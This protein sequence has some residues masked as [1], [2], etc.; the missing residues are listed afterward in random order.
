[1]SFVEYLKCVH[2]NK[3]TEGGLVGLLAGVGLLN[4]TDSESLNSF[5]L[6]FTFGSFYSLTGTLFGI[7]T[8]FEYKKAQKKIVMGISDHSRD[9]RNRNKYV[10]CI[11]VGMDLAA[12]ETGLSKFPMDNLR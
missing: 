7:E 6:L 4:L 2:A 11:R 1:M 3:F 10:Y 5:F 9:Y 12:R 8:Y